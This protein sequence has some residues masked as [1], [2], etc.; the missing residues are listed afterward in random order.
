MTY[1]NLPSF[2]G[3]AVIFWYAELDSTAC[4]GNLPMAVRVTVHSYK[5]QAMTVEVPVPQ[6]TDPITSEGTY[7]PK[8]VQAATSID[9]LI[10]RSER[11]TITGQVWSDRRDVRESHFNGIKGQVVVGE[12]GQ[13][14]LQSLN[15]AR[16]SNP[17]FCKHYSNVRFTGR[18]K[19]Y[20]GNVFPV[21]TIDFSLS[22]CLQ[23]K[24]RAMAFKV[25]REQVEV[26]GATRRYVNVMTTC[27]DT[28]HT[29]GGNGTCMVKASI[30]GIDFA[31]WT[32]TGTVVQTL[33]PPGGVKTV[34][35]TCSVF[36]LNPGGGNRGRA[37][38]AT[39]TEGHDDSVTCKID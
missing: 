34:P 23:G 39:K 15:E 7:N 13:T 18:F 29:K 35:F 26:P 6:V 32:V 30:T 16:V 28:A 19:T 2:K 38:N 36:I 14:L 3:G 37:V 27:D 31:P 17:S 8:T 10:D 25:V 9:F 1:H 21:N 5:D 22:N 4:K 24:A 33:P 20:P 12:E 11:A